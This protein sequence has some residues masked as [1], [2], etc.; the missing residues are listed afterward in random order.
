MQSVRPSFDTDG[1]QGLSSS[2]D[3]SMFLEAQKACA[4][5]SDMLPFSS[6]LDRNHEPI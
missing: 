3:L 2:V 1:Q 5:L 6:V 4:T